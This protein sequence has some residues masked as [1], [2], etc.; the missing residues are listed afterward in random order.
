MDDQGILEFYG[1]QQVAV[2]VERLLE[3]LQKIYHPM[4][5]AQSSWQKIGTAVSSYVR[6]QIM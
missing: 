6:L 5:R 3:R 2:I 1:L 4:P